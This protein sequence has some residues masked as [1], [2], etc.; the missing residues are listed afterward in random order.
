MLLRRLPD[1]VPPARHEI[2]A[3][4]ISRLATLHGLDISH[5]WVQ[6]TQREKSGGM[7]RIV[8]PERLAALTGRSVHELAGAM[9][10]LRA[11]QPDWAMFR[12]TPQA[13]CHRCDARHPGGRVT[14]LLPHHRYV[15][16]RHRTWIGPP[17]ADKPAAD[18]S[19]LPAVI[20]AQHRHLRLRRR[21]GWARTFDAVLTAFSFCGHIWDAVLVPET[22]RHVWHTWDARARVLIPD[23]DDSTAFRAYSTSKL[24]AA[25]YPEAVD[26]AV[27]IASPYWR[28]LADG[29]TLDRLRFFQE[30]SR[31]VTYPYKDDPVFG[32][33]IAHWSNTDSWRPPSRPMNTYS[34]ARM[35]G[36]IPPL[37]RAQA[38]RHEKS[39]HWFGINRK[40]GSTLLRHNHIRPIITREWRPDY[41][42]IEGAIW[43]SKR[44]GADFQAETARERAAL[45][46]FLLSER[47]AQ[48]QDRTSERA[49]SATLAA[50]N[51][52]VSGYQSDETGN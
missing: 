46:D 14:R 49:P 16:L 27:I 19:E 18:L 29:T 32:D 40:A 12:H 34:P 43:H 24:F 13:G 47:S 28:R 2:A 3:S 35:K 26:L 33:A 41:E 23:D 45:G 1:P 17:D 42:R 5:L 30:I 25:V 39:A 37:H 8:I 4:Y 20:K 38:R 11:P 50:G 15:C 6:V 10:E 22:P 7:R 31:R 44:I 9:P 48:E 52:R 51:A 21:R 36:V